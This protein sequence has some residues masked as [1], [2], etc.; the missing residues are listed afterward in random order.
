MENRHHFLFERRDYGGKPFY[1][2]RN[3]LSAEVEVQAHNDLHANVQPP[4]RPSRPLAWNMLHHLDEQPYTGLE[5]VFSA[6]DYLKQVGNPET[7][8]L[9]S[10]F[11]QQLNY[12]AVGH[13]R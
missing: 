13:E 2:L 6:V 1:L 7:I 8:G 12:V 11:L 5:L 10:N 4:E 3:L 9:A